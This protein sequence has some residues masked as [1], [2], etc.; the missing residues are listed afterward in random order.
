MLKSK[1]KDLL[2]HRVG[3]RLR[4]RRGELMANKE[5][6]DTGRRQEKLEATHHVA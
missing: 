3:T 2:R 6:C 1:I 5:A 4:W